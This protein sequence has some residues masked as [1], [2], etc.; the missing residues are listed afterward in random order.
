E[1]PADLRAALAFTGRA[2][3]QGAAQA[4]EEEEAT[5][6]L[7]EQVAADDDAFHR[8]TGRCAEGDPLSCYA[9]I[10]RHQWDTPPPPELLAAQRRLCELGNT[11][12]HGCM[13]V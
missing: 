1:T 8:A 11:R 10:E 7:I 9:I 12:S 6:R 3:S 4:C 13:D 2:C 5:R